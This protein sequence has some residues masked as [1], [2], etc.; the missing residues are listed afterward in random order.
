[1]TKEYKDWIDRFRELATDN[2]VPLSDNDWDY[3]FYFSSGFQPEDAINHI[4]SHLE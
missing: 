4:M 1:M 2:G 3:C